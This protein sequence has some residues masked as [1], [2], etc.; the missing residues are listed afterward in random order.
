MTRTFRNNLIRLSRFFVIAISVGAFLFLPAVSVFAAPADPL[1]NNAGASDVGLTTVQGTAGL[2]TKS[3]GSIIGS[4]IHGILGTMGV[5]AIIIVIYAGFLWMTAAGSEEQIEKSKK[6]LLNGGIGLVIIFS[7]YAITT[8]ILGS[9]SGATGTGA[10]NPGD[11]GENNLNSQESG[12]PGGGSG[13]G[14]GFVLK[15]I[16]PS[17]KQ[18]VANLKVAAIFS[19]PVD[20]AS[21]QKAL[22]VTD[23]SG[24]TVSGSVG[25]DGDIITFIPS[26][27]CPNPDAALKCFDAGAEYTVTVTDGA[28]GVVSAIGKKKFTCG[29]G[30]ST[31]FTAGTGVD[32]EGPKISNTDPEDGMKVPVNQIVPVSAL[33]TDDI[34]VAYG[35]LFVDDKLIETVLAKNLPKEFEFFSKK[36]ATKDDKPG[37]ARKLKIEAHDT[38]DNLAAATITVFGAPQS[39]F[40]KVLDP[41]PAGD[42]I[43]IDCSLAGGA[44]NE[45]STKPVIKGVSPQD[46]APGNFVTLSGSNFGKNAGTV[47]FLGNA[48][49]PK[50]DV[51]A[52]LACAAGWSGSQ[53][54]IEIPKNAVSG[55]LQLKNEA[56]L[57]DSTSDIKGVYLKSFTINDTVRPGICAL[58]PLS[59]FGGKTKITISGATGISPDGGSHE[60]FF[61]AFAADQPEWT[62]DS[63]SAFVPTLEPGQT[64]VQVTADGVSSNALLFQITEDPAAEAQKAV[65]SA[66]DPKKGGVGQFVSITG[67]KFGF[68]PNKVFF[69]PIV[70]GVPVGEATPADVSLPKEC[71]KNY[72]KIN[73]DDSDDSIVI[74][75]PELSEGEYAVTVQPFGVGKASSPKTFTV[76]KEKPGPQVCSLVADTGPGDG[77]LKVSFYGEHLGTS[78][79][80]ALFSDKKVAATPVNGGWNDNNAVVIVPKGAISGSVRVAIASG[81]PIDAT[82]CEASPALCSNPLKFTAID[83]RVQASI[84]AAGTMCCGDGSCK[85]SCGE[86]GPVYHAATF[87]WCI[88]TGESCAAALPPRIVEE[89]KLGDPTNIDIPSPSP[90]SAWPSTTGAK[91]CVNAMI[92]VKMTEP[93]DPD[94]VLI[95]KGALS[96]LTI[97]RCTGAPEAPCSSFDENPVELTNLVV[98][99]RSDKKNAGI[100]VQPKELKSKSTYRIA[101]T[102]GIFG[103]DSGLPLA[104]P[105]TNVS[106][107]KPQGDEVYCFTFTTTDDYN[108]CEIDAVS[109]SPQSY[110]AKNLGPIRDPFSK[111]KQLQPWL[112]LAYAQPD[113]CQIVDPSPFPWQ[114]NPAKGTDQYYDVAHSILLN[115]PISHFHA[116]QPTEEGKTIPLA[117]ATVNGAGEKL[118]GAGL[119][120]INPG[121]PQVVEACTEGSMPSPTPSNLW[122]DSENICPDALVLAQFDQQV[123]G[124]AEGPV[125]FQLWECT[126]TKPGEECK[127]V[128]SKPFPTSYAEIQPKK[129]P[130]GPWYYELDHKTLPKNTFFLA[131]IKSTTKVPGKFGKVM[132]QNKACR[133]GVGY[134]FTFKTAKT[135]DPCKIQKVIISPATWLAE[136]YGLQKN[137]IG[138]DILWSAYPQ[139]ENICTVLGGGHTYN[140]GVDTEH[141]GFAAIDPE[142]TQADVSAEQPVSAL[143]ETVDDDLIKLFATTEGITGTA[144]IS[145]QFPDPTVVEHEPFSC[146][147]GSVCPNAFMGVTF[148][149]NMDPKTVSDNI[150]LYDCGAVS[151]VNPTIDCPFDA[152][153][154]KKNAV[155]LTASPIAASNKTKFEFFKNGE[156]LGTTLKTMT[157]YRLAVGKNVLSAASKPLGGLNFPDAPAVFLFYSWVFSTGNALCTV[158]HVSVAPLIAQAHAQG[159]T[160]TFTA[161]PYT[162]PD[163]CHPNGQALNPDEYKWSWSSSKPLVAALFPPAPPDIAKSSTSS[164]QEFYMRAADV[165]GTSSTQQSTLTALVQGQSKKGEATWKMVCASPPLGCPL[166][167]VNGQS[168]QTYPGADKC[169][170]VPAKIVKP[171]PAAGDKDVCINTLIKIPVNTLL[172]PLT[173]TSSTVQIG[174]IDAKNPCKSANGKDAF[175]YGKIPYSANVVNTKIGEKNQQYSFIFLSLL[176]TLPENSKVRIHVMRQPGQESEPP[177]SAV[178]SQKGVPIDGQSWDFETGSKPCELNAVDVYPPQSTFTNLADKQSM[179][180]VGVSKQGDFSIP[181]SPIP[182]KY[183]WTWKWFSSHTDV[184]AF[185]AASKLPA[186]TIKPAGLNGV[187]TITAFAS[188]T[189]DVYFNS[190]N[191]V[192]G[193]AIAT[194]ALCENPWFAETDSGLANDDASK[195]VLKKF[196]LS[197]WYCRDNKG[198][199]NTLPAVYGVYDS[200]SDKTFTTQEAFHLSDFN[201]N[202]GA[203][204]VRIESNLKHYSPLEWYLQKEFKG[205]AA[206][207]KVGGF[208]AVRVGDT[209]YV[210]V[211]N[212]L[213]PTQQFTNIVVMSLA[214]G[215]SADMQGIFNQLVANIRFNTDLKDLGLCFAVNDQATDVQCT[216][217]VACVDAGTDAVCKVPRAKFMR[218][219]V[220]ISDASALARALLK[221]HDSA[222]K[223]PVVTDGTF[224]PGLVSS[225]WPAWAAFMEQLHVPADRVDPVNVYTCPAG[226]DPET[227]WN[228][229]IKQYQ[230]NQTSYVYHYYSKNNGAGYELG[231][232]F[233]EG[234]AGYTAWNAPIGIPD[235]SS[236][237]PTFCSGKPFAPAAVCGDGAVTPGAEEC[238]PPDSSFKFA[239]AQCLY[240]ARAATC[241]ATCTKIPGNCVNLCG[242]GIKNGPETCDEGPKYNGKYNHCPIDCGVKNQVNELGACG[243]GIK[244]SNEVCEIGQPSGRKY[245]FAD[246]PDQDIIDF[247]ECRQGVELKNLPH[248]VP[249]AGLLQ[250]SP[251]GAIAV[252]NFAD[253]ITKFC[254]GKAAAQ[255][256]SCK[257]YPDV[258]CV[259]DAN[260]LAGDT[261]SFVTQGSKHGF[262]KIDS[263]NWNCKNFG[264]YCGDKI[265][266]KDSG[267]QCD[268]DETG[269]DPQTGDACVRKCTASCQWQKT[270]AVD[271]YDVNNVKLNG[272]L[273]PV[274]EIIDNSKNAPDIA[275]CGDGKVDSGT[276][277]ECDS[278]T[279]CKPGQNPKNA[280]CKIGGLNN[281]QCLAQ[282]GAGNSCQYCTASCKK[283][284]VSGGYCGDGIRNGSEVCDKNDIGYLC[285]DKYDY[286]FAYCKPDCSGTI[287]TNKPT[288]GS[289]IIAQS[290][291]TGLWWPA[292]VLSAL[293]T[294]DF[295]IEFTDGVQY[296]GPNSNNKPARASMVALVGAVSA[297]PTEPEPYA[298]GMTVLT[299]DTP[300]ELLW[301]TVL[302][303]V[304]KDGKVSSSLKDAAGKLIIP[305]HEWKKAVI[306]AV[307]V[308]SYTVKFEDGTIKT[309]VKITNIARFPTI[310][311]SCA[312]QS[313][314]NVQLKKEPQY[315]TIKNI[316]LTYTDPTLGWFP[317]RTVTEIFRGGTL[318]EYA[319]AQ[320]DVFNSA[321]FG[322][323]WPHVAGT[324]ATHTVSPIA[325]DVGPK[326][327]ATINQCLA[328]AKT[329][330]VYPFAHPNAQD[331]WLSNV[332]FKLRPAGGAFSYTAPPFELTGTADLKQT[333]ELEPAGKEG[334][335]RVVV[336]GLVPGQQQ[337]SVQFFPIN[338]SVLPAGSPLTLKSLMLPNDSWV[339][340]CPVGSNGWLDKNKR[341]DTVND[342]QG[343]QAASIAWLDGCLTSGLFTQ[344]ESVVA[345]A[346]DV[347][348]ATHRYIVSMSKPL[349]S[350]YYNSSYEFSV[351]QSNG[352]PNFAGIVANVYYRAGAPDP[353]T[354][355]YWKLV[356]S[357]KPSP[358]DAYTDDGKKWNAFHFH[359]Q[360]D[361]QAYTPS[362]ALFT[363]AFANGGDAKK[364]PLIK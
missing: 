236:I 126:S 221:A 29:G 319:G 158:D 263:C 20:V 196:H 9:V 208:P 79:G 320:N 268:G 253:A 91:V 262:Q 356:A 245:K 77:T 66:L 44:C 31:K 38:A 119:L 194:A 155:K 13:S 157:Q 341:Y 278:G 295:N 259:S 250:F 23:A 303:E 62:A 12:G 45:C 177:A 41:V 55:P 260:C 185:D 150:Y 35:R 222:N 219:I 285:T 353:I 234:A 190:G 314:D 237:N 60:L 211:G 46:G 82:T 244:Q 163:A 75:V 332:Q 42:E 200:L 106:T 64:E 188:T 269:S 111:V 114:W 56:G 217:D 351:Y 362:D 68:T 164:T 125:D 283:A 191:K 282:Y 361:G 21:A 329:Y 173:I 308:G 4:I 83:C 265:V 104:G 187:S 153:L 122:A 296:P 94:S 27:V 149:V 323:G 154:W 8:F 144:E 324:A 132:P 307:G 167:T 128:T 100:F 340:N 40:N 294:G 120:A 352:A 171:Y 316:E 65:V 273:T 338:G 335:Y 261:C 348:P 117:I 74:K 239:D 109:M 286:G 333:V 181:L 254:S 326:I 311:L 302:A 134:C 279:Q 166:V 54:I 300:T 299:G 95:N 216:S 176:D 135:M 127:T 92:S 241:S 15:G 327:N 246:F 25:V 93:V 59:G 48:L 258:A 110:I 227:C 347:I 78:P 218:D 105:T 204:G 203:I 270:V 343:Y 321:L 107:C 186:T 213:S 71:A 281:V 228:D 193:S 205:D 102:G 32:K 133:P 264:P 34:A 183:D 235:G 143:K 131:E 137:E 313:E 14:A 350:A 156:K 199:P 80:G 172:D 252:T 287:K 202:T 161:L 209:V 145:V 69:T 142:N 189:V 197:F 336:S 354:N 152:A 289:M 359:A 301:A 99:S 76:T 90:M 39:C 280:S 129:I 229:K 358:T 174:I 113:H 360:Q 226:F 147:G 342:D 337:L 318:L 210:G 231:I 249:S 178:M 206:A 271:V 26:S 24:A 184:I 214:A 198:K 220:R 146:V 86:G 18:L 284:Y 364:L 179:F 201:D 330:A 88:S 30:C 50:D 5:I 192:A 242:D 138:A 63:V 232:P 346:G 215:S 304:K 70:G 89:C 2:G 61:S 96:T 43:D 233:E 212:K 274:C 315:S 306:T 266:N 108:V 275:G 17:G 58:T 7:A 243:D 257:K 84:C 115:S 85:A 47:T 363:G 182:N 251:T 139:P 339:S 312:Q 1:A 6:L 195:D 103:F 238:D 53:V 148:S 33:L 160:R 116:V 317:L 325:I 240:A 255:Y 72:W 57:I 52:P 230:C 207:T 123:V 267:E 37:Q 276:G 3:L 36:F 293:P 101:L 168:Q 81:K 124:P 118:V 224:V 291:S 51:V 121:V 355:Q 22:V 170:Y 112:A 290:P 169:C 292:V 225:K 328:V 256:G 10:A 288:Q 334:D 298:I 87:A 247:V 159:E 73:V 67:S 175:C 141:L 140:W 331:Q 345:Y 28:A 277:E 16:T 97:Q 11:G 162:S 130:G 357:I 297:D 49:D 19:A 272:A 98:T 136:N 151:D 344:I 349:A 310:C 322:K 248:F 309:G 180:S 223:F 165:T 305:D